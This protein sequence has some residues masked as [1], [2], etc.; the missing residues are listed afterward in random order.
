M[1]EW[2]KLAPATHR[3]ATLVPGSSPPVVLGGIDPSGKV[4]IT[5][6]KMYDESHKLWRNIGS[7]SSA[8]CLLAVGEIKSGSFILIGGC[9][10]LDSLDNA[11]SSILNVVELG[12][13]VIVKPIIIPY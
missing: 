7:L 3:C 9:T 10:K 1:S 2:N 4:P 11:L 6:I 8:K 5:D 12:Q 13:A